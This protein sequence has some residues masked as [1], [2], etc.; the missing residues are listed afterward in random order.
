MGQPF[1]GKLGKSRF[2]L[3]WGPSR[4]DSPVTTEHQWWILF[5]S[6]TV[7]ARG[8]DKKPEQPHVGCTSICDVIVV[9]KWRHH[10]ASQRIQ[11]FLE[12]L[13]MFSNIKCSTLWWT[14]K[15]MHNSC[16]DGIDKSVPRDHRFA[17]LVMSIGDPLDRFFYAILTLMMYSYSLCLLLRTFVNC[18][19]PDQAPE[20][21][22][23][24]L[25][26]V[27]ICVMVW[28]FALLILSYFS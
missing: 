25:E 5:I 22:P 17:S 4:W 21:D 13:F 19:D 1:S 9:L 7:P 16:E 8:K 15:R 6:Q 27:F 3:E 2:P 26:R 11:D 20:A 23:G 18:L 28:G 14:S 12:A 10:V 24:F